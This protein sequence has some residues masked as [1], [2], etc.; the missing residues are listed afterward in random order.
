MQ[1]IIKP[2]FLILCLYRLWPKCHCC[3]VGHKKK[4]HWIIL[5][6]MP[7]T[8][9]LLSVYFLETL[10]LQMVNECLHV[11]VCACVC[12]CVRVCVC[13]CMCVCV[14]VY[15]R[16]CV[17]ECVCVCMCVYVCEIDSETLVVLKPPWAFT[18]AKPVLISG[19]REDFSHCCPSSPSLDRTKTMTILILFQTED[20]GTVI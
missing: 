9:E 8:T 1:S 12:V 17:R 20:T 5:K 2:Q 13:V 3:I 10:S 18:F 15:A 19:N 6:H 14:C 4:S 16:V 11:C 7:K